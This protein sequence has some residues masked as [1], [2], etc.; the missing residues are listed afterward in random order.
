MVLNYFVNFSVNDRH[1]GTT[2]QRAYKPTYS[3]WYLETHPRRMWLQTVLVILYK[4]RRFRWW[5]VF[6]VVYQCLF[7]AVSL[8]SAES[9]TVG[10]EHH[11]DCTKHSRVA[12]PSLLSTRHRRHFKSRPSVGH[13]ASDARGSDHE[14]ERAEP[15]FFR[16]GSSRCRCERLLDDYDI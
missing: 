7:I 12:V 16:R 14:N 11:P 10:A 6:I 15:G 4:V 1:N 13:S 9:R 2:P 5:R 3:L 8:Q